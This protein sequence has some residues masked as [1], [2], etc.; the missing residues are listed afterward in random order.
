MKKYRILFPCNICS[1]VFREDLEHD[2]TI[3]SE[4]PKDSKIE[5]QEGKGKIW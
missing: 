2:S 4:L 5:G 3:F 1:K